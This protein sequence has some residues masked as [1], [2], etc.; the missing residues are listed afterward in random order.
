[1]VEI[2]L[3]GALAKQFGKVWNL[4]VSSPKE[5]FFAIDANAPGFLNRVLALDRAGMC[6]RV[7]TKDH[8]YSN[9]DVTMKLGGAK[10]MDI[11][12]IVMGAS[13]G[14]RFVVGATL[15]AIGYVFPGTAKFTVPM[16]VSLMLG[17]VVEWLTKVPQK[18]DMPGGLQSWTINGPVNTADQGLPVPIIYGEVLTGGHVVSAGI[19]TSPVTTGHV[20]TP[21]VFI[22]GQADVSIWP[23]ER[24]APYLVTVVIMLT[25]GT[26]SIAEPF[27]YTWGYTGLVGAQAVRVIGTNQATLTLEVDVLVGAAGSVTQLTGSV[28]LNVAGAVPDTST[29]GSPATTSASSTRPISVFVKSAAL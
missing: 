19:S 6:F 25:A 2:R 14:V 21:Y 16:G 22:G 1:M 26:V 10:R 17:S 18:S 15:V 24:V 28:S 29:S 20:D 4:N 23:E 9:E 7:R 27:T 8:D 13:A 12:P 5:A 11:I 3:H